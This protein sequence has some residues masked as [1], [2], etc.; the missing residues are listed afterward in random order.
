[1][2]ANNPVQ[3]HA[4]RICKF[5]DPC[6]I[7][8]LSSIIT[9]WKTGF[10]S[11]L[12]KKKKLS[13]H[14]WSSCVQTYS[15]STKT[16]CHVTKS[17][18]VSMVKKTRTFDSLFSFTNQKKPRKIFFGK[19]GKNTHTHTHTHTSALPKN[20]IICTNNIISVW[21]TKLPRWYLTT[22]GSI[23]LLNSFIHCHD[24]MLYILGCWMT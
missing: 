6:Y 20:F 5:R 9:F 18:E 24:F 12:R 10:I 13:L 8:L 11:I 2:K 7:L 23:M 14:L 17:F 19:E 16:I 4:D 15:S 3:E 22:Y 1:M 21:T